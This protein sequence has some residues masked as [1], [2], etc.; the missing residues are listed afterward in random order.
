MLTQCVL[1]K[2]VA[3]PVHLWK[4]KLCISVFRIFNGAKLCLKFKLKIGQ[5][6]AAWF[7]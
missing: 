7:M 5:Q 4:D 3:F 6:V 2:M 1:N